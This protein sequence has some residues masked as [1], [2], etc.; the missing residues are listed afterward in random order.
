MKNV[1]KSIIISAALAVNILLPTRLSAVD[2]SH[3]ATTSVLSEG[4][5]VRVSISESGM[6]IVSDAELR[7]LGFK[8]P[9]KVR[10]YGLGGRQ[11]T[12]SL[13]EM[14]PDDLPQIASVRT[15]KGIVFFAADN[16]TWK[17][18][19]SNTTPYSHS[20]NQYSDD[21]YY[22][23]SDRDITKEIAAAETSTGVPDTLITDFDERYLYEKE[24]EYAGES[25]CQIFGE[26]FRSKRSQTFSFTLPDAVDDTA[27]MRVR[28]GSK[29]TNGTASLVFKANGKTLSATSQDLITASSSDVYCKV[30][31]TSKKISNLDGSLSLTI[32]YSPSGVL[33]FARLDYIE[34]FYRRHL[35]LRNGELYFYGSYQKG[36]GLEI[37][38]CSEQTRIWDVTTPSSPKE[39]AYT[40]S[41]NKARFS[42]TSSGYREFVAFNP[43]NISRATTAAKQISNQDLHSLET[44]DMLILTHPEYRA[45]AERIAALHEEVDSFRVAVL[46]PELVFNE[47]SGGKPDM[48]AFRK[49]MKMW[50]DRGET[51]DGHKIRYCILMGKP[52]Y[53]NKM[54]SIGKTLGFKPM[55]TY[56]SY[57]GL[58]ESA[59]YC[60]D[61]LIGMLEDTNRDTDNIYDCKM[62]VAVGRIPVTDATESLQMATKIEKYVKEPNYG[63][64]RNKI[65]L[66]ADD[67][68]NNV[69]VR[70]AQ[71]VYNSLRS[72]GNG[73]H[74]V[75]DRIY[76]DSYKRVMTNVGPTYPQA[77]E[78]MKRNYDEGV[79]LT[80]YI[81]HA[82]PKGWGH[83]HLWDWS[84]IISMTNKNLTFLYAATCSF[85]YWDEGTRSGAEE[86]MINPNS[87]IIGMMGATRSV[88]IDKNGYLN[89]STAK[90]WFKRD[91]DGKSR[92]FGDIYIQGKMSMP[93]KSDNMLRYTFM[94]DPAIRVPDMNGNVIIEKIDGIDVTDTEVYP[95]LMAQS[96]AEIEGS[97]LTPE[98]DIDTSFNGT[99]NLQ[100]YDAERV[101]TTYGQGD[102][103]ISMTYN[104]RD[105]RLSI[106]SAEVKAGQW[107]AILRIPPEIQGNYSPALISAYATSDA[108][109]EANGSS[110]NLILYGYNIEA[111]DTIPPT[112][113]KFYV[114]SE[115]FK[116]GD[117]VNSSPVVFAYLRDESGINVSDSGIGH[118]ITLTIDGKTSISGINTYFTAD[119]NDSDAGLFAYPLSGISAGKHTIQLTVWDNANNV[120]KA[121]LDVNI[122]AAIDPVIYDIVASTNDTQ[123]DFNIKL[124]R[125]NTAMHCEFGVYDLNGRRIWSEE[126]TID[127]GMESNISTSWNLCDTSG[128]RVA[129]GI[130]IYRVTV[131]TPE[132]TYASKSKKIAISAAAQ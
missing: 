102:N 73:K 66:I 92:R 7:K 55:L 77:T 84:D 63:A 24:L 18:K 116:N 34:L 110:S 59:S 53:D 117:I 23:L 67:E 87:G 75:Y 30:A 82:S 80:N 44:P 31:E 83:E 52:S 17:V 57:S 35:A 125:P 94:G 130:Y 79:M 12:W 123:I 113:E 118:G 81:G 90:E 98:G 74:Y 48:L 16:V 1:H 104:D 50:H 88:L 29:T 54:V 38:G 86:I 36:D 62:N 103:G 46:D 127:S 27:N 107:K 22:F 131:E 49:L 64:W 68:D 76:L 114:N 111:T 124:D 43:D 2:A 78:R 60:N 126:Q 33:F 106:A 40:L 45:G 122:G 105:K 120:S 69:H 41:G 56:E 71:D 91:S 6:H 8:D 96:S 37:S 21:N 61:D 65:Q 25:G 51:S 13:N 3:Y 10:V 95:E 4:K 42:V 101:I 129:R 93:N 58:Q 115:N 100:L 39:V 19:T 121:T 9:T 15:S 108:G 89:S 70:Q 32:D 72:E 109:I 97:I 132:G 5:W 112:I 11:L 20:I 26:D 99:L 85:C 47:F 128:T 28:F 14:T 119:N